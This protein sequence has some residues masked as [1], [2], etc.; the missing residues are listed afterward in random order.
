M[1]LTIPAHVKLKLSTWRDM[2]KT[3]VTGFFISE[4]N[5][6][7]EII[8]A[9][10]I[11]AS[12]SPVTIDIDANDLIEFY[13]DMSEKGIFPDQ[14]RIW[15]HTHP[16]GSSPSGTDMKTFASLN[17]DRSLGVMYILGKNDETCIIELRDRETGLSIQKNLPIE[18]DTTTAVD[19]NIDY[20][21]LVEE[22][23]ATVIKETW[24]F[25]AIKKKTFGFTKNGFA[26]KREVEELDPEDFLWERCEY[27]DDEEDYLDRYEDYQNPSTRRSY[28]DPYIV[29]IED[30]G[31]ANDH[32]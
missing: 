11:T 23:N 19:W 22:Y 32:F 6:P 21:D 30:G 4:K 18:T 25:P 17:E 26:E 28:Q 13:K 27:D 8:D 31:K 15:W 5:N 29:M 2:G 10:M 24:N 20:M 1:K 12:V 3:E 9:R 16:G 7:L 14:L